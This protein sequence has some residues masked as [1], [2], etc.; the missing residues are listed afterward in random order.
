MI[1]RTKYLVLWKH[2]YH[3][4]HHQIRTTTLPSRPRHPQFFCHLQS[5]VFDAASLFQTSHVVH[6]NAPRE[7]IFS[8]WHHD[9]FVLLWLLCSFTTCLSSG[10]KLIALF[11]SHRTVS[12]AAVYQLK[13]K[14]DQEK[15]GPVVLDAIDTISFPFEDKHV[16]SEP[17]VIRK[18][19][20]TQKKCPHLDRL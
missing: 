14:Y 19:H 8:V 16:V 11:V 5:D 20:A 10:G 4:H 13:I 7:N 3:H 9:F 6:W 12:M 15:F 2:C 18:S 1:P 17:H